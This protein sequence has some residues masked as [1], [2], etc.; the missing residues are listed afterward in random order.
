VRRAFS[1][2]RRR[3]RERGTIPVLAAIACGAAIVGAGVALLLVGILNLR[4]ASDTTLRSDSLLQQALVVEESV[5]N[6]E[7]AVRGYVI[8]TAPVFLSPLRAAQ[9]ALPKEAAVL[10]RTATREHDH[11]AGARNLSS[12]AR[13]Y[14]TS[15][16]PRV[17]ALARSDPARS[18]SYAVTLT[19]K[20]RVDRIRGL[21]SRLEDALTAQEAAR[22]RAASSTADD[23]IT[24]AVVVLVVLVLLTLTIQGFFGRLL[25]SRQRALRRS[26]E[27]TKVLQTSLLPLLIPEMPGCEL[28]IRFT[29]AGG[30]VGVVGGDFYD[31]FQLRDTSHWAVVVGDVCGKGAEAAATTAVARWTLRS[32][33]LLTPTPADAI[34]HLND[35]MRRRRQQNLFA[36]ISY[37]LFDIRENEAR[38]TVVCAGHPP[39]IV[40]AAGQAPTPVPAH[41]DLVG[42]WPEVRMHTSE[43]T[44]RPGDLI[45]AYTD[46]ATDFSAEAIAPLEH[47]ISESDASSASS[48]AAAIEARALAGRPSPRDD[49]AVV[50]IQ[51]NGL[52]QPGPVGADAAL[53]SDRPAT[54]LDS[55]V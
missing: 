12:A 37:L 15:Y 9:R 49:I 35:V 14:V 38:V 31:V 44:L 24:Y 20:D 1:G 27:T 53:A 45:V 50:V 6:A 54:M 51:F 33:S 8:T 16:I 18:R 23:D 7:T 26:G 34:Q 22:Q 36:T 2:L 17:I 43:V 10:T 29:P 30:G 28:A 19:G 4:S 39:P 3:L 21:A 48:L 47:F 32:A 52:G 42:I 25:L 11:A 55:A 40:L 41:G 5:V 13:N 46:G